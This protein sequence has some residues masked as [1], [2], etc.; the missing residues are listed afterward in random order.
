MDILCN[1]RKQFLFDFS[2]GSYCNC[3]G[4]TLARTQHV[5]K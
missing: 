4:G 3:N 2:A 5:Q 1:S